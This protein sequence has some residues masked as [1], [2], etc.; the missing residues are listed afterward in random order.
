M[1]QN[2]KNPMAFDEK[3]WI[4]NKF[5]DADLNKNGFYIFFVLNFYFFNFI[6]N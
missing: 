2:S 4:V 3:L 1:I 5:R 6:S